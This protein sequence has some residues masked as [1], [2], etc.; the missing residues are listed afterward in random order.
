M[1][2]VLGIGIAL[3]FFL[4]GIAVAYS[5]IEK[6]LN[7]Q[8]QRH[9]SRT[10][11]E[12]EEVERKYTERMQNRIDALKSQYETQIQQLKAN[13]DSPVAS[14]DEVP[15]LEN[16]EASPIEPE[17][18]PSPALTLDS[19]KTIA[20]SEAET[21]I[22]F[23][24]EEEPIAEPDVPSPSEPE[25]PPDQS[26]LEVESEFKS[27]STIA[28]E[29][30]SDPES[31]IDHHPDILPVTAAQPSNPFPT[32]EQAPAEF[33]PTDD[34]PTNEAIVSSLQAF[35]LAD[36]AT[37]AYPAAGEIRTTLAEQLLGVCT[38]QRPLDL[39]LRP[40]IQSLTSLSRDPDP[41]LRQLSL[42]TLSQV[43]SPL[44]L[45]TLRRGLRDVD[46]DVVKAA[47]QGLEAWKF[48]AKVSPKTIAKLGNKTPRSAS[49]RSHRS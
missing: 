13:L 45:P 17:E 25:P 40:L 31:S 15:S 4:A 19:L 26:E 18:S 34:C 6:R 23:D 27:T 1:N 12:I 48:R 41:R 47:H 38:A 11:R 21:T 32:I 2:I 3:I 33:T 22:D 7:I 43:R 5:L 37:L 10:R 9:R 36:L 28:L 14:P 20:F 35:T 42:Q 16:P 30:A 39:P 24:S 44:V 49:G 8:E 29:P 46:S